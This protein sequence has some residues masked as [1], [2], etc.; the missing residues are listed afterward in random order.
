[1]PVI[2]LAASARA[3]VQSLARIG[4]PAVAIDFFGDRDTR[5]AAIETIVVPS[6]SP[7][8]Q[9]ATLEAVGRFPS[10]WPLV[11]GGAME[12]RPE[13]LDAI[14]D[15]REVLGPTGTMLRR[16]RNR[17]EVA[18][19]LGSV[20][21]GVYAIPEM[22]GEQ[23]RPEGDWLWKSARSGCGTGVR[24]SRGDGPGYWQRRLPG[25][26]HGFAFDARDDGCQLIGATL[27]TPHAYAPPDRPFFAMDLTLVPLGDLPTNVRIVLDAAG[28]ALHGRGL[29]GVFGLDM[30]CPAPASLA[31]MPLAFLEL[32]PRYTAGMELIERL[33][34]RSV[35][36]SLFGGPSPAVLDT[37][38]TLRRHIVLADG[39]PIAPVDPDERLTHPASGRDLGPVWSDRPCDPQAVGIGEPYC[40]RYELVARSDAIG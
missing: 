30:I 27:H 7:A 18:G 23:P 21:L 29:R 31:G 1:M 26:C 33:T 20:P 22:P 2:A 15:R 13:L 24:L 11:Y 10:D 12:N 25:D 40:T 28:D 34:G 14:A 16:A 5:E 6:D 17:R 32:N 36:A 9:T 37:S 35:F 4:Q 3:L 39:S 19:V 38:H 8:M